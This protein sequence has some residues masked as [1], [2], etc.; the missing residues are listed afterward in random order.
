M[1]SVE[2]GIE[3][4]N[5]I[6]KGQLRVENP[7]YV[8]STDYNYTIVTVT[9]KNGNTLYGV[10]KLHDD[11]FN[12]TTGIQIAMLRL[13]IA[14]QKT[15]PHITKMM[16]GYKFTLGAVTFARAVAECSTFC[17]ETLFDEELCCLNLWRH[18]Q[19]VAERFR[20]V[21]DVTLVNSQEA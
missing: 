16:D 1:N 14:P 6:R 9:D 17:S 19:R 10:A 18:V 8:I 15:I 3:R 11:S 13:I 20:F 12:L 2:R 21:A 5:K 4:G 7:T